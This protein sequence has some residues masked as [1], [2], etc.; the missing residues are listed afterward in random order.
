MQGDYKYALARMKNHAPYLADCLAAFPD[1]QSHFEAGGMPEDILL[2]YNQDYLGPIDDYVSEMSRLRILKRAV[3]LICA[4]ADLSRLWSWVEVT[5]ALSDLADQACARILRAAAIK[6]GIE[7]R[8]DNPVP[9]LFIIAMGKHGARE[10]NYSSDIDFTVFY[11]PSLIKLPDMNKAERVLIRLTRDVIKGLEQRTADGYIFRTDLRLRPDPR[12]N[13]IVVSTQ[14]AER[15][16]ESLGQNWERAALIKARVCAG[17][18]QAGEAFARDVLGPFIWRR[19]LDYAAIDDIQAIKRQIDAR[20]GGDLTTAAGHHVKL[21]R[22]GIREIEFYA[23]VQQLIL[24]G[25]HPE[26]RQMRTLKALKALSTCGFIAPE[27][28]SKLS[29]YYSD[30]RDLEHVI[31]MQ[32]DAQDHIL[33]ADDTARLSLADLRGAESL[34][35]FDDAAL[36]IFR[37]VSRIYRE[38]YHQADTLASE[39]GSL[40]F[41][42]VEPDPDTLQTL[43]QMGFTRSVDIWQ[44]M[45]EWLG[46]RIMATRTVRARE[47]LTQLA[48]QLLKACQSTGQPDHAFFAFARFFSNLRTGVQALSMFSQVPERLEKLIGFMALSD[49]IADKLADDPAIMDAMAEPDYLSLNPAIIR[50]S[51]DALCLN[52]SDFETAI[53]AVR[54]LVKEL[55]FRLILSALSGQLSSSDIMMICSKLADSVIRALLP[56]AVKETERVFGPVKGDFAIIGL[57]KL[58][59]QEMRLTSDLDMM[60]IYKP[61][62]DGEARADIYT[63]LTQRLMSALSVITGEGGLY[64]VDLTLRP[65]GRSGPVAV[66]LTAFERYYN[67]KAW[68]WEFMALTRARIITASSDG[69]SD[70]LQQALCSA[71]TTPRPDLNFETDIADMLRRTHDAKPAQS[72]WDI[73]NAVGGLRD[74]EYIAQAL[75][76]K[77]RDE[78]KKTWPRSSQDMIEAN[79]DHLRGKTDQSLSHILKTYH[80]LQQWQSLLGLS[81]NDKTDQISGF[82]KL[83]SQEDWGRAMNL[84]TLQK[85]QKIISMITKDVIGV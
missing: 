79:I 60:L 1:I 44:T 57:G 11:D 68:S 4:V 41:T 37:D 20:S 59:G 22:G 76:L 38:L 65:S 13:A 28:T 7:G 43:K 69:F 82:I 42:G 85:N 56:V 18:S 52:H 71:I 8:D 77:N 26:L 53:N 62:A 15:Y 84:E 29:Q 32:Y 36:E 25:R 61:H 47:L 75:W 21:G 54:V 17:D 10:L 30:L 34:D 35:V 66:S 33:P 83:Y 81:G 48:P 24:G 70:R 49:H 39:E 74:I 9:G 3:H 67:E 51:L 58:G 23:Q 46:G 16:Y 5:Q 2:R 78:M 40:V 80:G 63:K 73:K 72:D 19:S 64:E 12:S 45:S 50:T 14:T 6:A 27:I 55:R 31:Q